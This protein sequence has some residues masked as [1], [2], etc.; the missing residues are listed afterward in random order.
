MTAKPEPM[1][2][3]HRTPRRSGPLEKEPF[4]SSLHLRGRDWVNTLQ[5]RRRLRNS[6]CHGRDLRDVEPRIN[7]SQISVNRGQAAGEASVHVRLVTKSSRASQLVGLTQ[8]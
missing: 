7:S 3:S 2:A 5:L 1:P 8:I 6:F 4:D